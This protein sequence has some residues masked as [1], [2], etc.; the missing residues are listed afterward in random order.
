MHAVCSI[1]ERFE[2]PETYCHFVL[3]IEF[4]GSL[5]AS[6]AYSHFVNE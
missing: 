1:L 3:K 6:Y 2:M 4:I 5:F